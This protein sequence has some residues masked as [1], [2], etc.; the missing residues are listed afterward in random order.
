MQISHK[1]GTRVL[2]IQVNTT[3]VL[4]FIMGLLVVD[5]LT[6]IC[7]RI[8]QFICGKELPKPCVST[9]TQQD[10]V[11]DWA[12]RKLNKN[13]SITPILIAYIDDKHVIYITSHLLL[14]NYLT[15]VNHSTPS[16][17]VILSKLLGITII[18]EH[19]CPSVPTHLTSNLTKS[20]T[21]L[22]RISI[23]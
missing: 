20:I 17:T 1:P 11:E 12:R 9:Y 8:Y 4:A 13:R 14:F 23:R 3:L 21:F 6:I 22:N 18:T 15:W 2:L 16:D 5:K 10:K 7:H 19:L